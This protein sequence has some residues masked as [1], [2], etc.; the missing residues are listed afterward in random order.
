VFINSD[1]NPTSADCFEEDAVW[2]NSETD[3]MYTQELT[4]LPPVEILD[5]FGNVVAEIEDVACSWEVDQVWEHAKQKEFRESSSDLGVSWTCGAVLAMLVVVCL[6]A[7]RQ[8][9]KASRP[10][11]G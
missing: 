11:I 2:W 7:C 8:A 6:V 1:R 9:L 4:E 5:N 3:V 10:G